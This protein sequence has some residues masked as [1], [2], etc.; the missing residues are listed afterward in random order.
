MGST[1]LGIYGI[2]RS[3]RFYGVGIQEEKNNVLED[4]FEHMGIGNRQSKLNYV[5]KA[6]EASK[7]EIEEIFKNLQL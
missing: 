2:Y 5:P 7:A 3:C 6:G 1:R 4:I